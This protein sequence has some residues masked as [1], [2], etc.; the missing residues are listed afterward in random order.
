MQIDHLCILLAYIATYIKPVSWFVLAE[1]RHCLECPDRFYA[2][3]SCFEFLNAAIQ[4]SFM[5][6]IC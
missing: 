3:S 5:F 2:Y 1:L 4:K 6:K